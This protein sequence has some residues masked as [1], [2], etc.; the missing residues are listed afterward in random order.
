M[1]Y[2]EEA[3][4][5]VPEIETEPPKWSALALSVWVNRTL[6]VTGPVQPP[7]GWGKT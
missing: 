3:V 6:E 5:V 7:A 4:I 2:A 1:V